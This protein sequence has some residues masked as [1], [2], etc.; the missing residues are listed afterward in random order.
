MSCLSLVW[1]NYSYKIKACGVPPATKCK[2]KMTNNSDIEA[3][4]KSITEA[5]YKKLPALF[6]SLHTEWL[7]VSNDYSAD[8]AR[9][10]GRELHKL[11]G[12]A[13]MYQANDIS[14]IAREIE[15]NLVTLSERNDSEI[16]QNI[17][18]A[19]QHLQQLITHYCV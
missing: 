6:D 10:L 15:N 5:Y 18:T 8:G 1:H 19:F 13:G 11:A 12:S 14:D 7:A 4:L 16:Q 9:T 3:R 17:N 2:R